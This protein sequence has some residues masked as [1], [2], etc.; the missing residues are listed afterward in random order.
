MSVHFGLIGARVSLTEMAPISIGGIARGGV[1]VALFG[2]VSCAAAQSSSSSLE[3][4]MEAI[5][6]AGLGLVPLFVVGDVNEDGRIDQTDVRLA[7]ELA[8]RTGRIGA[9][10]RIG[11]PAAADIDQSGSI[12]DED[13]TTLAEWI[14]LGITTPALSYLSALPCNFSRLF[15]AA[16]PGLPRDGKGY[17]RF[18]DGKLT[19]ANSTVVVEQGEATVVKS[20]DRGGFEV[21]PRVTARRG[22]LVVLKITLP[23]TRTYYYSMKIVESSQALPA[24]YPVR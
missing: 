13:A 4:K 7:R 8:R 20:A 11:C 17:L 3:S 12:G 21:T 16:S 5:R 22:D 6:R 1:L 24:G 18:L 23:A 14:R 9:D 19:T 15:V 2:I 10:K